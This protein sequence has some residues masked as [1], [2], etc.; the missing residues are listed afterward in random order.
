[1]EGWISH[2]LCFLNQQSHLFNGRK[3]EGERG[4]EGRKKGGKERGRKGGKEER[5]E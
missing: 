3:G 1:M 4:R 2:I 5:K